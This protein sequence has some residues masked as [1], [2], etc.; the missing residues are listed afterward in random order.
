MFI[1]YNLPSW[2]QLK[3]SSTVCPGSIHQDTDTPKVAST[4]SNYV[5]SLTA[6]E[7]CNY[8]QFRGFI[9]PESLP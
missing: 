4:S 5:Y 7:Y 1:D 2:E 8:S 3:D 9:G 6:N